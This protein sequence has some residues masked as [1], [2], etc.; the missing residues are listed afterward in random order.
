MVLAQQCE[1]DVAYSVLEIF[2]VHMGVYVGLDLYVIVVYSFVVGEFVIIGWCA[3][4]DNTR[5][6]MVSSIFS[7]E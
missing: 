4:G 7:C 2:S 1:C 5:S 3:M 6:H